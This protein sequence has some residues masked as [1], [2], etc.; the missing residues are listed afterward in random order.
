[1]YTAGICGGLWCR[2]VWDGAV[3]TIHISVK[4]C[5]NLFVGYGVS[6]LNIRARG[7]I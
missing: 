2:L 4:A 1:M 6:W 3:C 5:H 7:N